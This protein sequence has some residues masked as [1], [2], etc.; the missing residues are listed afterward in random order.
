MTKPP[1]ETEFL[2]IFDEMK[3]YSSIPEGCFEKILTQACY[4]HYFLK[5]KST[6]SDENFLKL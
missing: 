5:N 1:E 6:I 3:Y 4:A 2:E